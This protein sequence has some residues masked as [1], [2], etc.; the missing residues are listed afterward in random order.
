M[1]QEQE[2][3]CNGSALEHGSALERVKKRKKKYNPKIQTKCKQNANVYV[4][5]RCAM[6]FD[7]WVLCLYTALRSLQRLERCRERCI[8][9]L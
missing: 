4:T 2:R 3:K 5:R 8:C 6:E 1:D 7:A 9:L